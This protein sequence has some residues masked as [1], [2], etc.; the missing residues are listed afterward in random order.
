MKTISNEDLIKAEYN[1]LDFYKE[2]TCG[3]S[4]LIESY[5]KVLEEYS[6]HPEIMMD[7]VF[8]SINKYNL[9]LDYENGLYIVDDNKGNIVED[10]DFASGVYKWVAK[11][12]GVS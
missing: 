1:L 10:S 11:F 6:N 8:H 9:E 3:C 5:E 7:S 2:S 12:G 4:S